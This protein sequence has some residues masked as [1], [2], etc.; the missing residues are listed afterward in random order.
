MNAGT[1]HR[2]HR[3]RIVPRKPSTG[4]AWNDDYDDYDHFESVEKKGKWCMGAGAATATRA[5][6]EKIV[7]IVVIVVAP[8]KASTGAASRGTIAERWPEKRT[9]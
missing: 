3:S 4:A 9:R 2:S 8:W 7:V 5:T 6:C 1:A